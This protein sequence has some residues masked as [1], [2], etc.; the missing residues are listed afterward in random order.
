MAKSN[1]L[2]N[3]EPTAEAAPK[4]PAKKTK[5]EKTTKEI[6]G[7]DFLSSGTFTMLPFLLYISFLAFIYIA[8]NYLAENKTREI[9]QLQHQVKELRYEYINAK[10]NLTQI[11]KQ[12]QIS[13]KLNPKGIKENTE[14]LKSI[15]IK[16]KD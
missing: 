12:S 7:G 4:A 6:L 16:N 5:F 14:P 8:N 1:Q 13:K 3:P 9:N 2:K 15:T 10:S 11:E